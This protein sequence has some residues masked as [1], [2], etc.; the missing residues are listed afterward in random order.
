MRNRQQ[1]L[2][3]GTLMG[4]VLLAAIPSAALASGFGGGFDQNNGG[5]TRIDHLYETGKSVYYA[6]NASG[7]PVSYCIDNGG[8]TE[9]VSLRALKPFRGTNADQL[10]ARLVRCDVVTGSA[11]EHLDPGELDAVVYYL[12]KRYKLA[13]Y[14][15]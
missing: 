7:G 11:A 6:Q 1:S 12:N 10:S 9:L 2:L 8:Q 15:S 13:L 3:A 5:Q 4:F 14:D